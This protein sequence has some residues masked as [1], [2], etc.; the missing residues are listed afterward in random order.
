MSH[1]IPSPSNL[2]L[3]RLLRNFQSLGDNCEFGLAQRFAGLERTSMFRLAFVPTDEMLDMISNQLWQFEREELF[4]F[5]VANKELIVGLKGYQL[6]Y[7][8]PHDADEPGDVLHNELGRIA[9]LRK[10][11][12][13]DLAAGEQIL[14]RK[15]AED[16][17]VETIMPL[18]RALRRHGPNTMLWVVPASDAHPAG[19]VE[20]IA[21]G[22]MKGYMDRF[23]PYEQAY[24]LSFD[25]WMELCINAYRLWKNEPLPVE[26]MGENLLLST[27]PMMSAPQGAERVSPILITPLHAG[28]LVF[29]HRVD[30]ADGAAASQW[31]F[32]PHDSGR[33]VIS[34]WVLL[35]RSGGADSVVPFMIDSTH[36]RSIPAD[37]HLRGQWQRIS[38]SVTLDARQSITPGLWVT[39]AQGAVMYSTGWKLEKG[40]YPTGYIRLADRP[41]PLLLGAMG[42]AVEMNYLAAPI[43]A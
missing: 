5:R 12:L 29:A 21:E 19:T 34:V 24:D 7:H 14:V 30:G 31:D 4:T 13:A 26:E 40:D 22:L 32:G 25:M 35:P 17:P 27:P 9:H 20:W 3:V 16:A 28:E 43:D 33:Y 15:S 41:S 18:F 1:P 39:G 2:S 37:T 42:G 6:Y 36:L 23:A 11:L 38:V 10:K 8:K